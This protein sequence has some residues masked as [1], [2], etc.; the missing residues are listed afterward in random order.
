[1]ERAKTYVDGFNLYHGLKAKYPELAT[2]SI[3]V[4]VAGITLIRL[5]YW[6]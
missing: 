4:N 2:A 6:T 3:V 1:M 5:K